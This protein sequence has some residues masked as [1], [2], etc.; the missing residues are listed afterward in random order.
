MYDV[1]L[2]YPPIYFDK[3]GLPKCLDV[4]HP[5]L[6]V[7]YLGSALQKNGFTV[8]AIDVGA[9]NLCLSQLEK[10]FKKE[11]PI[12]VGISS[13]TANLRGAVQTAELVKRILPK[14]KV[15]LGGSHISADPDFV[16]RFSNI[17]DF[18][19]VGEAEMT[20]PK[21]MKDIKSNRRIKTLYF[22]NP[23]LDVNNIV[24]PARE[25]LQDVPYKKGAMIF[26]SRGCPYQCIFCSRPAIDKKIRYRS[27]KL[28]VDEIES[29]YRKNENFFM[30]E[31]DTLT[32]NKQHILKICSEI[33]T[34]NLTL[35]W[36]GITRADC[37]DEEVIKAMSLAGCTELTFG[38]E[39][40]SERIRNEIIRKNLSDEMI[41][42]AVR[43]C[44]KHGI[45]ANGFLMIG[46]PTETKKDIQK[47]INFYK[48]FDFNIVGVHL[49]I[50]LPG[51]EIFK[52]A[53]T[54]KKIDP[55]IIDKYALGE[56]GEGFHGVWPYYVPDGFTLDELEKYRKE[57]YRKFYFRLPYIWQ[58]LKEDIRS[59]ESI[60]FD[61]RI[62]LS[63][64]RR[65]E[66][67]RQ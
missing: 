5:P 15:A 57:A 36:T 62:A 64:L 25:L 10:I 40:G 55:S 50:P 37:V 43:L 67:Q 20:F 45:K 3:S 19:V 39:S 58:R 31:D 2:I 26:T 21:I 65:G 41:R 46:F 6:G 12:V 54:E 59:W 13:M 30:F 53:L 61:I 23:V 47:T 11:K 28:V 14:A 29:L 7:L 18:G 33:N 34:R 17:I 4:E 52:L 56:L 16:R 48:N 27:P 51:S 8:K 49:T 1:L 38:I 9:E 24:E 60:F 22:S 44:R 35:T 42:K 63:L 32:L 66:S